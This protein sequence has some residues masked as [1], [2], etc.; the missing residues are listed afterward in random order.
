MEDYYKILGVSKDASKEEI[1]KAYRKLAHK[2]HPDKGG[3]EK[4][5][6]KISEA[7][8]VLSNDQKRKQYDHFGKSGPGAGSSQGAGGFGFED[9]AGADFNVNDI[10]EEFFGF[11]RGPRRGVKRRGEDIKIRINV[12]LEDVIKDQ[13]KKINIP[14]LSTCEACSGKGYETGTKIKTCDSCKGR[15]KVQTAIGPFSQVSTCPNCSGKGNIPEKKCSKCLGEGRVKKTQEVK[16]VIPAGID[17]GQTLRVEGKGN[18]GREGSPPGDLLVEII[19]DN[20]TNFKRQGENLY[21]AE[22][23]KLAQAVLGDKI[24]I[25]TIDGKSIS[26]KIPPGTQSKEVFKISGKGMPR[27]S[28]YGQG[29]LYVTL[30]VKIPKKISRKQRKIFEELREENI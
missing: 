3:D 8:H 9:F 25:K 19:V 21:K 16:F 14:K 1:K 27:L 18:V 11:G 20:N 29:N 23:I 12:K 6:K 2:H 5:F 22:E 10:F 28:G 26:L 15:G 30:N 7:Y 13:E 17:S 24:D 4:T